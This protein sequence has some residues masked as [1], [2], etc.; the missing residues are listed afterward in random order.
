MI[1]HLINNVTL[2]VSRA[3]VADLRLTGRDFKAKGPHRR[4]YNQLRD[5]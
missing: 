1:N 4:L 2:P 3:S 5:R